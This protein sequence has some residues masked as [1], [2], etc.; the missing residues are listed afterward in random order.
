MQTPLAI[1]NIGEDFK[2]KGNQGI[3][4]IPAFSKSEGGIRAF[5]STILPNVFIAAGIILLILIIA[6]GIGMITTAGNPEAQEKSK[7]VL[8]N[9]VIG[10]VIIFASYW[11]IQIIQVLTGVGI[12]RDF[13]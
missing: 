8:T 13:N 10:F 2:L 12:L 6:G 7:G 4:Q 9:A 1:V 3:G 11:I 5:I